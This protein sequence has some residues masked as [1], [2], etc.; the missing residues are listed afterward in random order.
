[1]SLVGATKAAQKH[2]CAVGWKLVEMTD[3]SKQYRKVDARVGDIR[4]CDTCEK[5]FIAE[6]KYRNILV[7]GWRPLT[8]WER[9]KFRKGKL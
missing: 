6:R 4:A 3:G 9:R 8:W 2:R 7:P 1:M 5:L